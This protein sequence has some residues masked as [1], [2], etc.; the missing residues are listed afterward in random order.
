M[1]VT[2]SRSIRKRTASIAVGLMVGAMLVAPSGAQDGTG[3]ELVP[4]ELPLFGGTPVATFAT[5]E[6]SPVAVS[7]PESQVDEVLQQY[8]A[9]VNTGDPTLVW[10]IFSPRW[11]SIE[12]ADPEEHYFPA[13][14]HMLSMEGEPPAIPLELVEVH[15]VERQDDGRV[16]VT[17]TFRSGLETWT[18]RLI[19]VAVEGQWMIDEV[20]PIDPAS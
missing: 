15:G 12:F 9:C 20:E 2:V 19:L 14:E 8:V 5:P 18:D 13:F 1:S 11:F 4:L 10:A 17:A 7:L 6:A 3:C 16:A